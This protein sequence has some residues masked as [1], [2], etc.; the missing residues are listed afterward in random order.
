LIQT[1]RKIF[2]IAQRAVGPQR[3]EK[4]RFGRLRDILFVTSVFPHNGQTITWFRTHSNL[5]LL[6]AN[7]LKQKMVEAR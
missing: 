4:K 5:K 2:D 6:I 1:D 3:K 7:Q